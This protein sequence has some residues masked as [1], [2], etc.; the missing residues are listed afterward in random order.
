M[1]SANT[2]RSAYWSVSA[3]IRAN[4]RVVMLDRL[5]R[6]VPYKYMLIITNQ[7]GSIFILVDIYVKFIKPITKHEFI[8]NLS[9]MGLSYGKNSI[10]IHTKNEVDIIRLR[11]KSSIEFGFFKEPED[12]WEGPI[13]KD[14][15]SWELEQEDDPDDPEDNKPSAFQG[16]Y[17]R[18]VQVRKIE[19]E[20]AKEIRNHYSEL[21]PIMTIDG[22]LGDPETHRRKQRRLEAE[23]AAKIENVASD[24]EIVDPK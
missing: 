3:C 14:Q 11:S 1:S 2:R 12:I 6:L 9:G 7:E 23:I 20:N 24:I 10:Q 17:L 16:A 8:F 5:Q 22:E 4:E 18:M 19:R 21:K 15:R 13:F